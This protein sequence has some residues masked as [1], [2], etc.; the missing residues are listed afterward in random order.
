M[1]HTDSA[2]TETA[3]NVDSEGSM[4]DMSADYTWDG[5]YKDPTF[6]DNETQK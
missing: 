2:G 4:H 6:C 1:K 5:T 3:Y